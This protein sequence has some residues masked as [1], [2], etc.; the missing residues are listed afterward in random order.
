MCSVRSVSPPQKG[1]GAPGGAP[2]RTGRLRHGRCIR[3][4]GPAPAPVL[5]STHLLGRAHLRLTLAV[6]AAPDRFDPADLYDVAIADVARANGADPAAVKAAL[7]F[8]ED[9]PE[10]SRLLAQVGAALDG[11]LAFAGF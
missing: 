2:L 11:L 1:P 3:P 7:L 9:G 10:R 8:L 4:S 6:A 5:A